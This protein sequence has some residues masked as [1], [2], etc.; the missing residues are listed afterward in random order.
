M[1]RFIQN[2]QAASPV[3]DDKE[4]YGSRFKT[5]AE[6]KLRLNKKF[7]HKRPNEENNHYAPGSV[8]GSGGERRL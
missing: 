3:F 1:P 5:R 6:D 2:Q 4:P 8:A 7:V